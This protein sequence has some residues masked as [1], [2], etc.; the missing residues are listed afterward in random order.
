MRDYELINAIKGVVDTDGELLTD[1]ECLD[2]IIDLV[3]EYEDFNF[4]GEVKS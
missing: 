1:G 2:K 3:K 4:D